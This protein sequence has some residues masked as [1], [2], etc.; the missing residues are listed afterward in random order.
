MPQSTLTDNKDKFLIQI[1][2]LISH[3]NIAIERVNEIDHKYR[4]ISAI[5]Q[6]I[7]TKVENIERTNIKR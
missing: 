3:L 6:R 4:D 2:R 5:L 7:E 1:T